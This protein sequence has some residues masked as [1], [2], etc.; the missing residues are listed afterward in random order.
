MWNKS[1]WV[2]I[3]TTPL[4]F[5]T[6]HP[7]IKAFMRNQFDSPGIK[8]S[9]PTEINTAFIVEYALPSL[10]DLAPA[11]LALWQQSER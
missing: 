8:D 7:P 4:P 6:G 1:V 9:Q 2:T 5:I 10:A 11:L 3:P